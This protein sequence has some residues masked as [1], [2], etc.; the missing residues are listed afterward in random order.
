MTD[1]FSSGGVLMIRAW[2]EDG[3]DLRIRLTEVVEGE[4]NEL[5]VTTVAT[6]NDALS[7]VRAW[8]TRVREGD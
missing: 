5:G 3:G 4:A 6:D 8:L 7:A 2:R 1:E